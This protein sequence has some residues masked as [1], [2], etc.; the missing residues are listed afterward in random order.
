MG[1]SSVAIELVC[2]D[3]GDDF[4]DVQGAVV[5]GVAAAVGESESAALAEELLDCVEVAYLVF[6][7]LEVAAFAVFHDTGASQNSYETGVEQWLI[8][9]AAGGDGELAVVLAAMFG[10]VEECP[11]VDLGFSGLKRDLHGAASLAICLCRSGEPGR[12]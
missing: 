10:D 12:G 2:L 5:E 6:V 1:R 3:R 4:V 9:Q 8:K 11:G 7:D